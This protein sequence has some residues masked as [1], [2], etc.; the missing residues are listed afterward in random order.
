MMSTHDNARTDYLLRLS[1]CRTL[2]DRQRHRLLALN[3]LASLQRKPTQQLKRLNITHDERH[4]LATIDAALLNDA[5]QWLRQSLCHLIDIHHNHYPKYLRQIDVP[6]PI[7][8]IYGNPDCLSQP[9]LAFVG[10]RNP[11]QQGRQMAYELS[12]LTSQH[13]FITVSGLALGIDAHAHRAAIDANCA[14]IAVLGTGINHQYPRHNKP[15]FEQ[16]PAN[17]GAL[18][19]ELPWN[20]PPKRHHFPLRNRIISGLSLGVV[21]VEASLRSGSLITAKWALAQNR[22]IFALPGF[23]KHSLSK[24][25]H[26]LIKQGAKLVESVE[27]IVVELPSMTAQMRPKSAFVKKNLIQ[28]KGS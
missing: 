2:A 7:L 14:T 18:V 24:G 10:S 3:N 11:S 20:S 23:A 27:D 4:A 6:P 5:K 21:V 8:Y 15:L 1:L 13:Q 28:N 12:Y 22:E 25:C 9:C 17:G 16:I 26:F 19:S